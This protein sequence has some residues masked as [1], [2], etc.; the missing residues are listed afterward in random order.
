[1][2][3]PNP[4]RQRV[5][6]KTLDQ[7]FA[8]AAN[9]W[10]IHYS[11][12]S[13]YE[14]REGR[15]PRI[16][17]I[18]VRKLDSAQTASFSI[19]QTAERRRTPFDQIEQ[20]YDDLEKEMLAAFF[21]HLGNHRG[22]KYVH[23]NMRDANYGFQA[24]EH[25]FRVLGEEPYVV[26]DANKTDLSRLLIDV[27]GVDYIGHPRMEKLLEKNHIAPLDFLSGAGEA[28]AF[29]RRDFVALHQSTLRKVDV[30]ANI[31][32]R[33]HDRNLKTNT[34]WWG[35]HGGRVRTALIWMAENKTFQVVAG[36]ASIVGLIL[37]LLAF[38]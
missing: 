35:M 17:S 33:A 29:E 1:M 27:Y 28:A 32:G 19:H 13:F 10:V 25:R 34:T 11:C 16:T 4:Q 20:H 26:D 21:T 9:V 18:A 14:R 36:I 31:A 5:A 3:A 30:I 15:S 2:T 22:M 12:E 24:I 37:A 23:W 8:D 7:L 38:R 6:L